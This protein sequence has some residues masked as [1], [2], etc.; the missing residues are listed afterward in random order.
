[1]P[2]AVG[3]GVFEQLLLPNANIDLAEIDGLSA[4]L[5][6]KIGVPVRCPE[7]CKYKQSCQFLELREQAITFF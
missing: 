4:F 6:K 3:F 5:K 1:L 7:N 2:A